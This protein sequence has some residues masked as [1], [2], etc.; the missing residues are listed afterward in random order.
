[1]DTLEKSIII[2]D[3]VDIYKDDPEFEEFFFYNDLGIAFAIGLAKEYIVLNQGGIDLIEET[4][5]LLCD[6][7]GM[8]KNADYESFEDFL[9]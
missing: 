8:D 5:S 7:F 4:Y 2:F 1:M 9:E 3:F 6:E